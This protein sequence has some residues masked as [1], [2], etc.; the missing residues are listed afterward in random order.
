MATC[1]TCLS[2]DLKTLWDDWQNTL[3]ECK[4][5]SQIMFDKITEIDCLR[6]LFSRVGSMPDSLV[7]THKEVSLRLWPLQESNNVTPAL[8][9]ASLFQPG[10]T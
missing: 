1:N 9:H 5:N 7:G 3:Y 6:E 10:F 4:C 8:A 2:E